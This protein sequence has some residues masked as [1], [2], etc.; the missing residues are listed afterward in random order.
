VAEKK[1]NLFEFASSA[2]AEA[3][4]SATKIVGC[5]MIKADL[6]GIPWLSL[7]HLA[8]PHFSKRV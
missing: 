6:L 8:V 3:G 1:L 2:M 4:A 5:E 7:Q